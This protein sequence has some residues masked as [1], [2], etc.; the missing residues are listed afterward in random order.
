M[1]R[2]IPSFSTL[3]PPDHPPC[4]DIFVIDIFGVLHD[5]CSTYSDAV[6]ALRALTSR[7]RTVLLSNSSRTGPQI[8]AELERKHSIRRHDYHDIITSG[9]TTKA[10]LIEALEAHR[11]KGTTE[12]TESFHPAPDFDTLGDADARAFA[13]HHL[14]TLNFYLLGTAEYHS[15]IYTALPALTLSLDLTLCDFVFLG[16]VIPLLPNDQ[17][18]LQSEASVRRHYDSFLLQCRELN[19]PMVCANP[20]VFSP[21]GEGILHIGSGYVARMYEE[22]GGKVL[23][24]GKPCRRVYEQVMKVVGEGKRERIVCVGDNL[25]TDVKG[26]VEAGLDVIWVAGGVHEAAIHGELVAGEGG[27]KSVGNL[28]EAEAEELEAALERVCK[29]FDGAKSTYFVRYLKW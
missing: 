20:D 3:F 22:A 5:G 24:F 18:D 8:V 10:F 28:Q 13:T 9:D 14:H 12:Y 26:A 11:T 29:K 2:L 16:A 17:L 4:Y 1:P 7:A 25:E 19:L 6:P 23:Y 15:S 27:K 21:Q